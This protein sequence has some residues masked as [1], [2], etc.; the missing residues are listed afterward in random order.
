MPER[1][2]TRYVALGDSQIE[3]IGDGD[4]LR[5]HRGWADRLAQRLAAANPDLR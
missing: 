5:G 4:D 1:S 2:Y 3:G